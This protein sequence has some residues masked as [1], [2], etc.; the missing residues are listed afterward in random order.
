MNWYTSQP[1]Y[2][3]IA[4]PAVVVLAIVLAFMVSTSGGPKFTTIK[5]S[6]NKEQV[7]GW[8]WRLDQDGVKS[9]LTYDEKTGIYEIKVS[10]ADEAEANLALGGSS[11]KERASTSTTKSC[12]ELKAIPNRQVGLERAKCMIEAQIHDQLMSNP[13]ILEAKVTYDEAT[14]SSITGVKPM[15]VNVVLFLNKDGN[16]E[17]EGNIDAAELAG[18]VANSRAGLTPDNVYI[19]SSDDGVLWAGKQGAVSGSSGSSTGCQDSADVTDIST[20]ERLNSDCTEARILK[21]VAPI[22]GGEQFVQ[23]VAHFGLNDTSMTKQTV[24]NSKGA[25]TTEDSFGGNAGSKTNSL[26]TTTVNEERAAGS[27]RAMRVSVLLDSRHVKTGQKL[28]IEQALT[29]YVDDPRN[30]SVTFTEFAGGL[31]DADKTDAMTAAGTSGETATGTGNTTKGGD[32]SNSATDSTVPVS[33][34]SSIP[35][36]VLILGFLLLVGLITTIALLWRRSSHLA[37]ERQA[38]EREFRS[39]VGA[40]SSMAEQDPAS[41]AAQLE[42]MLGQPSHAAPRQGEELTP[43]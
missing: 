26:N 25:P 36:T 11:L 3:R 20:K 16:G 24:R 42:A 35:P 38:F 9:R 30:L 21:T 39:E 15:R 5:E 2:I 10:V 33:A 18:M 8:V 22:A 34:K 1:I 43:R 7:D 6:N 19:T 23:V 4:I 40:F 28:A 29:N 13:A 32:K 31:K 12:P 27:M 41:I 17:I 37:K 14:D